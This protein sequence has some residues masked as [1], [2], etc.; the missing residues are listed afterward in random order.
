MRHHNPGY[1]FYN[2]RNRYEDR[3]YGRPDEFRNDYDNDEYRGNRPSWQEREEEIMRGRNRAYNPQ[4]NRNYGY[5]PR[6]NWGQQDYGYQGGHFD[7]QWRNH[8]QANPNHV[9]PTNLDRRHEYYGPERGGRQEMYP[10]SRSRGQNLPQPYN[11]N[12]DFGFNAEYH[13]Y[14]GQDRGY[15]D[16]HGRGVGNAR[17]SRF[18]LDN[19]WENRNRRR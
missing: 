12:Q 10:S 16:E 17:Y 5:E 15:F 8:P 1:N 19:D 4:G 11:Y 7:N 3:G 14:G 18:N 6:E 9:H 13:D 2:D